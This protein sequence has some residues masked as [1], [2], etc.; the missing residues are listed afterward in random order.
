MRGLLAAGALYIAG[1]VI[2]L[3]GLQ[4]LLFKTRS[5]ETDVASRGPS[6]TNAIQ[7]KARYQ[8]LK[9]RQELKFAALNCWNVTAK[10][11]PVSL[12]LETMNFSD[13]R[14]F[15]LSGTAPSDEVKE[16]YVFEGGMRKAS[17][18]SGQPLFDPLKGESLTYRANQ[19]G[20][21]TVSWN[22]TLELKRAEIQ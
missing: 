12:T 16:L 5:V 20:S 7:L 8:V 2:Y 3:I 15:T 4:F 17:D 13:G 10:L 19:V 9:D 11:M 6:Y 21:G 1:V 18:E 22:F 14:R